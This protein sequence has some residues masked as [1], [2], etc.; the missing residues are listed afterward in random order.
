MAF[1]NLFFVIVFL[2]IWLIVYTRVSG[3]ERKN[4]V[5]LIFSLIFYAFG[6]IKYLIL[7]FVLSLV[8]YFAALFMERMRGSKK[9]ILIISLVIFIGVLCFYKYAGF[10]AR[11][12][13]ASDDALTKIILPLGISFYIFKLISYMVDV[14]RKDIR[15]ERNMIYLLNY[16]LSFHHVLQGPIIRYAPLREELIRR[17]ITKTAIANGIYR[18]SIGLSKKV[19]LADRIGALADSLIPMSA[20]I[21]NQ[22]TAAI[23]LG[24]IFFT[25]QMYLDFSA[26][27]DMAIGLGMMAGFNYEENFNYPYIAVSVRDFWRRWHITLSRFFRDYVYIPLGGNRVGMRRLIIN[28]LVVWLLTGIW[29]GSTLNFVLWGL[30]YFVFIVIENFWRD[31]GRAHLPKVVGH[32]YAILVFN[33]GWIIFRFT[34]FSQLGSAFAGFFGGHGSFTNNTVSMMFTNNIFLLI[35]GILACTPFFKYAGKLLNGMI[36]QRGYGAKPMFIARTVV[37]VLLLLWA[38]FAMAGDTFTPFLYNQ[39]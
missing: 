26:Y 27:T 34:D 24:S 31:S 30:F 11:L 10:F 3:V 17:K 29:H 18:F 1:S 28:L 36:K 20:E 5:M 22:P 35:F 8:G 38:I 32:I 19:L 4:K 7:I 37:M 39:F 14:Y 15:A 21:A 12:S 25:L 16:T 6:G 23:W 33:F 9:I 2:P 13:A